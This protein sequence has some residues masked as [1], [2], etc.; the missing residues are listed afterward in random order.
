VTVLEDA[1]IGYE[2]ASDWAP[3]EGLGVVMCGATF[4]SYHK[5]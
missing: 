4:V 2:F 1:D 5:E 3:W